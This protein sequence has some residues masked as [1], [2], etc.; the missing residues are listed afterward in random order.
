MFRNKGALLHPSGLLS[1]FT[2]PFPDTLSYLCTFI[3]SCL[4]E[5]TNYP[6]PFIL[7][8]IWPVLTPPRTASTPTT[9]EHIEHTFRFCFPPDWAEHHNCEEE[10]IKN[11]QEMENQ[12]HGE[13]QAV[14]LSK[15]KPH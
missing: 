12:T 11:Q 4:F 6:P 3:S 1:S 14:M 5:Y 7:S 9:Q 2:Y 8:T 13:R 10:K 15:G